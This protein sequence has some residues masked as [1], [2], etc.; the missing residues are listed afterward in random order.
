MSIASISMYVTPE[1]LAEAT[2]AL[3]HFLRDHLVSAGVP[4][5]PKELD[6][7]TDYRDVWLRPDLLLSQT[8]GFPYAKSLRGKVRLVATPCY[9]YPGCDGAWMRSFVITNRNER[10]SSLKALQGRRAAINSRDSNSGYN[11]FRATLSPIA[12]GTSFFGEVIQTGGHDASISAVADGRADC[13]AID[14]VTYGNIARYAS[15]RLKDI[16]ILAET[17]GGPGLPF[18]TR[19]ISSDEDVEI[20]RT[21][22]RAALVAPQLE[23]VLDGMGIVDFAF[24]TD[25]DYD[26]LL[27]LERN[28]VACGYPEIA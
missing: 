26:S 14:C 1:P 4:G 2:D 24:L 9:R 25:G 5:V 23:E 15:E 8:C 20:L 17:P 3:W 19:G 21:A 18:I 11:L 16:S 12:R 13:A 27:E 22:L 10:V 6:R 28:A 7:A